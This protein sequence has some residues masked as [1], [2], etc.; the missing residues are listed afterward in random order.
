ME[1][2]DIKLKDGNV[3]FEHELGHP[4]LAQL[5]TLIKDKTIK[6][7]EEMINMFGAKVIA[8]W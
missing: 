7:A 6:A 2:F 8:K 3:T 5:L 1:Q 4:L